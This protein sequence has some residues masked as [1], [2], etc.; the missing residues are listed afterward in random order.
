MRHP[1]LDN[2]LPYGI[3]KIQKGAAHGGQPYTVNKM[4]AVRGLAGRL[5]NSWGYVHQDQ[6]DR[7]EAYQEAED[8]RPAFFT[9]KPHLPSQGSG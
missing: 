8:S 7:D 1:P 9:H 6:K 3:I 5:T 2:P 4:L